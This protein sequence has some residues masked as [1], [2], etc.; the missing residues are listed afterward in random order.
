MKKLKE[1]VDDLERQRNEESRTQEV[2]ACRVMEEA[3]LRNNV[4]QTF[5]HLRATDERER[6]K[7]A[8]VMEEN[9]TLTLPITPY[10]FFRRAEVGR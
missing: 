6:A 10:R 1:L 2:Q 8:G 4:I 3:S 9:F 7:W 5:L